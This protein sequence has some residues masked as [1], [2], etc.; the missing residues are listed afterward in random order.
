MFKRVQFL[1]SL[2]YCKSEHFFPMMS[3]LGTVFNGFEIKSLTKREPRRV[4]FNLRQNEISIF[5]S[6]NAHGSDSSK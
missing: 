2:N 1:C 6:L 4:K 5:R 3:G